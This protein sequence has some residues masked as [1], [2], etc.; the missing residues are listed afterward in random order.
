MDVTSAYAG[1]TIT[2]NNENTVNPASFLRTIE[3]YRLCF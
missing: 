2:R 1:T 3:V